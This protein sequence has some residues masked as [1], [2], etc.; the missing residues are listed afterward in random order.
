M[1]SPSLTPEAPTTDRQRL[2]GLI[3]FLVILGIFLALN[4]ALVIPYVLAILMGVMLTVFALPPFSFLQKKGLGPKLSAT[5]VVLGVV[6]LFIGPLSAFL[7][8]AVKQAAIFGQWLSEQDVFSIDV[9]VDA[10]TKFGPVGDLFGGPETLETEIR[11]TIQ[12]AG[13]AFTGDIF[14]AAGQ[15]PE[16]VLQLFLALI[17]CFFLLL[18]GRRFL[19]WLGDRVPLGREVK[20]VLFSSFKDTSI[21]VVW[22][23]LAAAI[24]QALLMFVAFISIG[25]PGAFLAAGA[26][27]V[28]AWVPILGS[29]PVWISGII[30]LYTQDAYFKV[31]LMLA[32]G[33]I[34]GIADNFVRPV[35]LKGRSDMHPLVSLI[36]I[37]GGI[38]LFGI[39]GVF[40]GPVLAGILTSLLEIWPVIGRRFGLLE[41]SKPTITY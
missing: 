30:Y 39:L 18:D 32:A 24:V 10:V 35:V 6:F 7:S 19:V 38:Q 27:F 17:T 20:D 37:F 9:L 29:T 21:S 26:T 13:K 15:L 8:M 16:I 34:T 28:F 31:S 2:S 1:T 41:P 4:I 11:N 36:A 22:S 25:V 3:I 33:V 12:N 40:V 23:T 14:S 5:I